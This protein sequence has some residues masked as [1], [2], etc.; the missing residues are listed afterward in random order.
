MSDRI[1]TGNISGYRGYTRWILG[2][3][4]QPFQR[5]KLNRN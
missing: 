5:A 4:Y 2:I 3:F 1:V